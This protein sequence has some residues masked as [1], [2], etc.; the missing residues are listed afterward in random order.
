[1]SALSY[2]VA[3]IGRPVLLLHA[4]VANRQMWQPQWPAL[5]MGHQVVRCDLRGFGQTPLPPV[6]G[7]SDALDLVELLNELA[8]DQVAVVGASYGGRV[9]L[10]LASVAPQRVCQLVLLSPAYRGGPSEADADEFEAA[11]GELLDDGNVEGAVALNVS[12]WLG[13]Q[14][15]FSAREQVAAWQRHTFAVQL[16]VDDDIDSVRQDVDAAQVAARTLVVTGAHD[17]RHF[18]GLARHLAD[19][20]PDARLVELDWAGHLPSL[21]RPDEVTDLLLAEL[22]P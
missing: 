20:M 22:A 7:W 17:L 19:V 4:G 10:E 3:G 9:A 11:E 15:S 18:Q 13:P 5:A 16:A 6:P 12:T 8:I 2:D 1:L 14:A 21:E